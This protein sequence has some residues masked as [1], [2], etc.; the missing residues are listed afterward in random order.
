MKIDT[1]VIFSLCLLAVACSEGHQDS[2]VEE[3][4]VIDTV[5]INEISVFDFVTND[6]KY[7]YATSSRT[8]ISLFVYD[9]AT[10][11][12]VASGLPKGL[13]PNEIQYGPMPAYSNTP[14]VWLMGFGSGQFRQFKLADGQIVATDTLTAGRAIA[15]NGISVINNTTV[16]YSDFPQSCS[17]SA[18]H[19]G[20]KE[21][22]YSYSWSKTDNITS[23]QVEENAIF[24][25]NGKIAGLAYVHD[26]RLTLLDAYNFHVIRTIDGG[27]APGE[28]DLPVYIAFQPTAGGLYALRLKSAEEMV[29]EIYDNDRTLTREINAPAAPVVFTVDESRNRIIA[30]N[31]NSP[32]HFLVITPAEIHD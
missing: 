4:A 29:F 10:L 12:F 2:V 6:G 31:T 16:S 28:S 19:A 20:D 25:S 27:E 17:I 30:Y 26:N 15:A 13:G 18:F 8:D 23:L 5:A 24:A 14:G 7:L 22:A 32:D 3:Q 11:K 1:I 9:L 21:P